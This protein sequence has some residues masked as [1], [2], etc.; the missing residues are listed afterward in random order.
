MTARGIM[1]RYTE[2][3]SGAGEQEELPTTVLRVR[4]LIPA[5]LSV[6]SRDTKKSHHQHR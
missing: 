3:C 4:E 5:I 6:L 2:S 1:A